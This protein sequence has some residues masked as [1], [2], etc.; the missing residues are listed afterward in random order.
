LEGGK[1][2]TEVFPYKVSTDVT[3]VQEVDESA[4]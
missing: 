2:K 1:Q 4:T 3:E